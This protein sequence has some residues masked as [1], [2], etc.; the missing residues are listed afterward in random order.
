MTTI[1]Q[2]AM[3]SKLWKG[4]PECGK[5][6]IW[7]TTWRIAGS[8]IYSKVIPT[9]TVSAS[10][11]SD[12]GTIDCGVS[13]S[14]NPLALAIWHPHLRSASTTSASSPWHARLSPGIW[15]AVDCSLA[16]DMRLEC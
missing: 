5:E 10:V 13:C 16:L 15:Y 7:I 6:K 4:A 2:G 8:T 1:K 12:P 11:G 3:D 14:A 9:M